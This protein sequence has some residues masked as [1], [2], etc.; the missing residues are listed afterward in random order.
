M[1]RNSSNGIIINIKFILW[2]GI[3]I[4]IL[5]V[6]ILGY[7]SL[8]Q[9]YSSDE[10]NLLVDYTYEVIIEAHKIQKLMVDLETGQRGYIITG[11]EDFLDLYGTAKK[12]IFDDIKNLQVIVSDNPQQVAQLNIVNQKIYS[13]LQQVGNPEI[14]ARKKYNR[15]EITFNHISD[16]L[17]NEAG[18]QTINLVKDALTSFLVVEKTLVAKRKQAMLLKNET[19]KIVLIVGVILVILSSLLTGIYTSQIILNAHGVKSKYAEI[20]K[21]LQNTDTLTIFASSL[22]S[23]LIPSI[24]A[25]AASIY[26]VKNDNA[27]KLYRIGSYGAVA[28]NTHTET[29]EK[30]QGLIG[31]CFADGKEILVTDI[32]D[33]YF[34]ICSSLG[35]AKPKEILLLPIIFEQSVVAVI[36]LASFSK[37]TKKDFTLLRSLVDSL[38][39]MINNIITGMRTEL[40]LNEIKTSEERA[41]GIINGSFDTIITIDRTGTVLSFNL[42]GEKLFGYMAEEVIGK[43]IKMLITDPYHSEHD[44]YLKNY[45]DTK[46]KIIIGIAREVQGQKK[47][48]TIFSIDLGISEVKIS[49]RKLFSGIIRDITERKAAEEELQQA[50]AE[51]EEFAY[52]TSH[53]LRS[54]IISSIRLLDLTEDSINNNKL[55]HA[56][57]SLSH[58]KSS[59]IKL[60]SLIS[61]ILVLTEVKNK[62]EEKQVIDMANLTS[63]TLKKMEYMEYFKRLDIQ[64]DF[65]FNEEFY[66]KK[67]RIIIILENLISNSIKYQDLEKDISYLKISTYNENNNFI[68]E[69]KDNGIGIPKN[70]Q[71]K[72][73]TMFKRFHPRVAFGSG[74]GLYLMKKS[75][76]VLNG[77]ISFEDNG[78]GSTFRLSIPV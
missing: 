20:L 25:Q 65:R 10:G 78:E 8:K 39:I 6:S 40:L 73:F 64:T 61:D 18:K 47:D 27:V 14:E 43:N 76:D 41:R 51:L 17:T 24:S 68:L 37:F 34:N 69:I 59:L 54:P 55:D 75:A 29:F 58:V 35:E 28:L 15:D 50:N 33:A 22:L 13:W 16:M 23:N 11:Q 77:D 5:L 30:G 3:V 53:D 48:G 9:I 67:L 71:N 2:L 63:E 19:T 72:M 62:E 57:V 38:G 70:Q 42:A 56:T 1:S 52:R 12:R 60:D 45:D 44:S 66:S 26:S 31:Q 36:E 7:V 21:S 74:L 4:P 49:G 46:K 32:P